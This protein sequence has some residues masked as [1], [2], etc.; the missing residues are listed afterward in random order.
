M[1]GTLKSASETLDWA[2]P[3]VRSASH[4]AATLATGMKVG[5]GRSGSCS[6]VRR[7]LPPG[8]IFGR[9]A[10]ALSSVC[11]TSTMIVRLDQPFGHI[12]LAN[13]AGVADDLPEQLERPGHFGPVADQQGVERVH[14]VARV[15]VGDGLDVGVGVG[16]DRRGDRDPA[17]EVFRV[18]VGD[19]DREDHLAVGPHQLTES[20][21]DLRQRAAEPAALHQLVGAQRAGGEDRRHG[22]G[23]CACRDRGGGRSA[24]W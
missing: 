16:V 4:S 10:I 13:F 18:V 3:P 22:R 24:R 9:S 2:I 17:G 6:V 15:A 1:F 14:R 12:T 20:V 5:L 21:G 7:T 8:I 19:R 23:S 11:I